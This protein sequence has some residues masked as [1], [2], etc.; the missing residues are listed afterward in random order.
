M[1]MVRLGAAEIMDPKSTGSRR[2]TGE[3]DKCV[4]NKCIENLNSLVTDPGQ[5]PAGTVANPFRP[6][7]VSPEKQED[8][9]QLFGPDLPEVLY[10]CNL[11]MHT[12]EGPVYHY[13]QS[14]NGDGQSAASGL[15]RWL[16]IGG[17]ALAAI[18]FFSSKRGN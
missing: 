3:D 11:P 10:T 18:W 15:P 12:P 1:P 13:I 17:L 5:C 4:L 8:L 7:D 6:A 14:G 16:L 9:R 2:P